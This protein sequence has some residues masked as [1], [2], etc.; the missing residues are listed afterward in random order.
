[1]KNQ[2]YPCLWFDAQDKEAV[3]FYCS[4]F[5]NSKIT[6]DTPM[7]VKWEANGQQFMG[8]YGGPM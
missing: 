3:E 6:S 2:I 5:K 1:M 4:I 8:F 7:V